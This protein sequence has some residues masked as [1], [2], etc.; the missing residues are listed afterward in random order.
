M[1]RKRS[2]PLREAPDRKGFS[3]CSQPCHWTSFL[4]LK[5]KSSITLT[6]TVYQIHQ[7][8]S[9][10]TPKD[11]I[12]LS[13]TSRIFRDTL[14][15]R[16][17]SFVWKAARERFGAPECPSNVSEPQ[18]TVLLFGN[19]CQVRKRSSFFMALQYLPWV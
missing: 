14:M 18:W 19:H 16:N 4:R 1:Q 8:F 6:L 5:K 17:A 3:A 10:L 7:V 13:R 2:S 9:H 15:M 11:V 12:H